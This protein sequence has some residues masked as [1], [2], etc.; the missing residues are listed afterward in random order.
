MATPRTKRPSAPWKRRGPGRPKERLKTII[1]RLEKEGSGTFE[2][3]CGRIPLARTT[4]SDGLNELESQG[5]IE[6][7][8]EP[9]R[10]KG[11]GK[12]HRVIIK[13]SEK[14]LVSVLARTLRHL[15][16]VTPVPLIDF[17]RGKELLT[18]DAINAIM[19]IS[20]L[21]LKKTKTQNTPKCPHPV[22]WGCF[23]ETERKAKRLNFTPSRLE[24]E[25]DECYLLK[26]LARYDVERC[27][28][29]IIKYMGT[30][31]ILVNLS[32]WGLPD[33]GSPEFPKGGIEVLEKE[34]DNPESFPVLGVARKCGV[35]KKFDALLEW[36]G[37]LVFLL[38]GEKYTE[39]I[40]CAIKAMDGKA[41][42]V[43][44][45]KGV[46]T[47]CE[48][49]TKKFLNQVFKNLG[50]KEVHI[51]KPSNLAGAVFVNEQIDY[52]EILNSVWVKTISPRFISKNGP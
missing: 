40:R 5:C 47:A 23:L 8:V 17:N 20:T 19:V 27:R 21:Y 1:E 48:I 26:A 22:R 12:R 51:T 41:Y 14:G 28:A 13:L 50:D 29:K 39:E 16:N 42:V 34:I 38:S 36:I 4:L 37:P 52:D 30:E 31:N 18:D 24:F 2:E 3:L 7:G 43:V 9:P 46:R 44:I 33:Y 15:E 10:E 49:R 45:H 32:P 6:R 11:K 35:L 25:L